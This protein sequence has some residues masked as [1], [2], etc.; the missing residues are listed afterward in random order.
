MGL[1]NIPDLIKDLQERAEAVRRTPTNQVHGELPSGTRSAVTPPPPKRRIAAPSPGRRL[2]PPPVV[3]PRPSPPAQVES[4]PYDA[5][6]DENPWEDALDAEDDQRSA[7]TDSVTA[8]RVDAAPV[9]DKPVVEEPAPFQPGAVEAVP[10]EALSVP[11]E[12]GTADDGPDAIVIDSQVQVDLEVSDLG[13]VRPV[14]PLPVDL[15]P[16]PA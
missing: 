9:A 3:Q 13:F 14:A 15:P 11:R 6:D 16:P 10:V 1:P 7:F 8:A 4:I 2:Q 5:D 12:R